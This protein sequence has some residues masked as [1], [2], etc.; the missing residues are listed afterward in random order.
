MFT[1]TKAFIALMAATA[2]VAAP[3]KRQSFDFTTCDFVMS[4]DTTVSP[5]S[6]N[7]DTE[8][9]FVIGRSLGEQVPNTELE[10]SNV[11]ITDNGNNTFTVVRTA[12]VD[13]KT[14]AQTASILTGLVGT[15]T[16]GF[17]NN[18]A[19]DWTFVSVSCDA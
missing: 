4:P 14:A 19:I 12:A 8:F 17:A 9:N 16:N 6:I 1:I 13:G 5:G 11:S 10:G 15:T 18:A 2:V 7:L 3:N